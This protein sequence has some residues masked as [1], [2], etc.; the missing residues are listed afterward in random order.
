MNAN[1]KLHR[2]THIRQG[3]RT[4]RALGPALQPR[5]RCSL[6]SLLRCLLIGS[7]LGTAAA[8][9]AAPDTD[10]H[11]HTQPNSDTD[12]DI[13]NAGTAADS[14]AKAVQHYGFAV[15]SKLRFDRNNFTQ[16]LEIHDGRL[17]VSSGLYGQSVIRVYTFPKLELLH[18]VPVDPRIFAEGLTVIGDRLIL[19]SWRERVMLVYS[20]PAMTL[21]GQSPLPGQGW[22]ATHNG[23]VL[24]FSDGS[25]RLYS[26]DL[27]ADGE[28]K[29][30][31]V[32]LAG[33]PLRNLNE[34]EWV[35]DE[36]WANVWQ[37]DNIARINPETGTVE[38]LI[39]L[40]G[41][42][43]DEDRLRDTDVLNGIAIDPEDGA[44]WVTGKR[45]PWLYQIRLEK[46]PP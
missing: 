37:T 35:G 24:W 40:S 46:N 17:Y 26:A 38:G 31:P 9:D 42:L 12:T 30:L 34:L 8:C 15:V 4:R 14:S 5:L 25:D 44:I 7:M 23:S 22:G 3:D 39:N 36:I 1:G 28:L 41:L 6:Q 16:G 19:L 33:K 45:W 20:L 10:T 29:M 18:S 43:A 11:T 13:Q 21:I 32:T 27:S 2:R